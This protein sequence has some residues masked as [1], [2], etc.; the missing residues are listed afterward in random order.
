MLNELLKHLH[1]DEIEVI[2]LLSKDSLDLTQQDRQTLVN[3]IE[4]CSQENIIIIHG[5]DTSI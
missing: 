3:T 2:T 4:N 5:T 1:N